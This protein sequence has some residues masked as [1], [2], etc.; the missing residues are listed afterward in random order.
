VDSAIRQH[1]DVPRMARERE[2]EAIERE[3][4]RDGFGSFL[5][6]RGV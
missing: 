1:A 3:L 2:F 4:M 5:K 6:G